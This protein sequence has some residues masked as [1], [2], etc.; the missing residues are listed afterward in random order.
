M[1][2]AIVEGKS[3]A[4]NSGKAKEKVE[5]GQVS[6]PVVGEKAFRTLQKSMKIRTPHSLVKEK[7][8]KAIR[9]THLKWQQPYNGFPVCEREHT[10]TWYSLEPN[11]VWF[12]LRTCLRQ[13][14]H[15]M[16]R[17][18]RPRASCIQNHERWLSAKVNH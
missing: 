16:S 2:T 14:V 12:L 3:A 1:D 10:P 6:D 8:R 4:E 15:G 13:T 11:E 17:T 7:A 18:H 9:L 5:R